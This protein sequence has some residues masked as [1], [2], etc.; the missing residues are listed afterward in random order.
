MCFFSVHTCTLS[1]LAQ[2]RGTVEL[3]HL[4]IIS[5]NSAFVSFSLPACT[6]LL[7]FPLAVFKP[8][9]GLLDKMSPAGT[10]RLK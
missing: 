8:D 5:A 4:D 7:P 3:D 6:S 9:L 1:S 2:C 10:K